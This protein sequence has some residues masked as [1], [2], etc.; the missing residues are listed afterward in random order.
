TRWQRET[1]GVF[2]VNQAFFFWG[3]GDVP[4]GRAQ[5]QHPV[6]DNFRAIERERC[7]AANGS[8]SY[9]DSPQRHGFSDA[10]AKK[11]S[12]RTDPTIRTAFGRKANPL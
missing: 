12:K 5:K 8:A 10:S 4:G 2:H 7:E 3:R 6:G 1:N 9:R 11:S